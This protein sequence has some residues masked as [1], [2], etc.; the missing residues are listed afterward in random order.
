MLVEISENEVKEAPALFGKRELFCKF[1][2]VSDIVFGEELLNDELLRELDVTG[3][4]LLH[5]KTGTGKTTLAYEVIK[6]V[7]KDYGVSPYRI[8]VASIITSGLGDTLKNFDSVFN[9]IRSKSDT[10]VLVLLDEFDR[11][12]VDRDSKVELSELKRSLLSIMDFFSSLKYSD[13]IM[14]IAV[15]NYLDSIDKALLRRFSFIES[16][17]V[18]SAE[19]LGYYRSKEELYKANSIALSE[20]EVEQCKTIAE[21]KSVLRKKLIGDL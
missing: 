16:V 9:D 4:F 21:L 11:F 8:D 14:L 5:G 13:K 7:E 18:S 19:V 17:D 10:G 15:T 2:R 20:S 6:L 3:T 12:V 1:K